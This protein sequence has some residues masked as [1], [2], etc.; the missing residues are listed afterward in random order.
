MCLTC[1]NAVVIRKCLAS[2]VAQPQPLRTDPGARSGV[3]ARE[4]ISTDRPSL[5]L[6][7]VFLL[8]VILKL[9]N[10]SLETSVVQQCFK[11]AAIKS[12]LK[13]P[14][15]DPNSAKN[16][17]PVSNLPHTSKLLERVVTELLSENHLSD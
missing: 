6:L 16:Y 17:R 13:K 5:Y 11:T 12:I 4:L 2:I 9:I 1:N 15:L 14:N 7:Q 10:G 8:P 3:G